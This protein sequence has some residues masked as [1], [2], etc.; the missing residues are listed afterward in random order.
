[1]VAPKVVEALL[2]TR[3]RGREFLRSPL[4]RGPPAA[5]CF[6]L[7][8]QRSRHPSM[9]LAIKCQGAST[10]TTGLQDRAW[11]VHQSNRPLRAAAEASRRLEQGGVSGSAPVPPGRQHA[12][13][14]QVAGSRNTLAIDCEGQVLSWGWNARGTLGHGHRCALPQPS[15]S[16]SPLPLECPWNSLCEAA[17]ARFVQAGLEV[18]AHGLHGART[19]RACHSTVV[20]MLLS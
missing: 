2:G 16:Q 15:F 6:A 17:Y 9:G 5:A 12:W 1:V 8:G 4:A 7:A 18:R 11:S 3:F 10:W 20:C 13:G 14:A 19:R